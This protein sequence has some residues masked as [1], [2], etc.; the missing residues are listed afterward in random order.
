MF[1][2]LTKQYLVERGEM[3]EG[4]ELKETMDEYISSIQ[5]TKRIETLIK[6]KKKPSFSS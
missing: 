5:P 3:K 4:Q 1:Y 6:T 2:L